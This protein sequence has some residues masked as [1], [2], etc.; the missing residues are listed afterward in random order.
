M[1]YFCHTLGFNRFAV[2]HKSF[3]CQDK[4]NTH[5]RF[6]KKKVYC[7]ICFKELYRK[8]YCKLHPMKKKVYHC[9]LVL[10]KQ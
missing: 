1:C 5:S 7:K 6:H 2:T 4:R 8:N 10:L 3:D 9:R